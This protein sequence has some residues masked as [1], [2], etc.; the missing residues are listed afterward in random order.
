MN[1]TISK[2]FIWETIGHNSL[3][4]LLFIIKLNDAILHYVMPW[5]GTQIVDVT[6]A[7]RGFLLYWDLS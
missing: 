2:E 5:M 3:S 4:Q 6:N 1:V 7:S